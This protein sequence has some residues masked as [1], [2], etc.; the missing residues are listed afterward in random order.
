[1]ICTQGIQKLIPPHPSGG[2][3]KRPSSD[4]TIGEARQSKKQAR[5]PYSV[6]APGIRVQ[7]RRERQD[8]LAPTSTLATTPA[9]R[10]SKREAK[11]QPCHKGCTTPYTAATPSLP[12]ALA[13]S[14][15]APVDEGA[16]PAT[17]SG[18]QNEN[19]M[20]LLRPF[21]S[22]PSHLERQKDSL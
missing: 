20:V 22:T 19:H 13:R 12:L 17:P 3:A 1:M 15:L 16:P 9:P 18:M 7:G 4:D 14:L 2:I 10:W 21:S 11:V 6:I 5:K 8:F